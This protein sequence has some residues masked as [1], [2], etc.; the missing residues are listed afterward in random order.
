LES[1]YLESSVFLAVINGES[2]GPEIRAL[3]KELKIARIRIYTCIITV[4]EIAVL[5]YRRGSIADDPSGKL[6]KMARVVGITKDMALTAA[7]LEAQLKDIGKAPKQA[8]QIAE[9]RRRK[10]DCFHIAA[11]MCLKCKTVY[12]SD[13]GFLK[14][15]GQLGLSIEFSRP[16]PTT[17]SLELV[18]V[19]VKKEGN[20]KTESKPA[21]G[22]DPKPSEGGAGPAKH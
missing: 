3:M 11:A 13:E 2:N 21:L 7:K 14:R 22:S 18:E 15:K 19:M 10:W 17:G 6:H 5:S 20:E 4:Q 16:M 8:D 1:V 12:S 9:N